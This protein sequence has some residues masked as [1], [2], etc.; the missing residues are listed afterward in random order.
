MFKILLCENKNTFHTKLIEDHRDLIPTIDEFL[1]TIPGANTTNTWPW[2]NRFLLLETETAEYML[3]PSNI[4]CNYR[5]LKAATL[6]PFVIY[7]LIKDEVEVKFGSI[8]KDDVAYILENFPEQFDDETIK[9][10]DQEMK[11][12]YYFQ[13]YRTMFSICSE[14]TIG[15]IRTIFMYSPDSV[16]CLLET[17]KNDEAYENMIKNDP[18]KEEFYKEFRDAIKYGRTGFKMEVNELC[19]LD[20]A[21]E[22][23]EHM[24]SL[25][26][27][28]NL[29]SINIFKSAVYK[30]ISD[31]VLPD[32]CM[33]H[34]LLGYTGCAH[35]RIDP[36]PNDPKVTCK[37]DKNLG[38]LIFFAGSRP[39]GCP[40]E[41]AL[42][43]LR[44]SLAIT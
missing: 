32:G 30:Q 7:K 23:E 24:E 6:K 41:E 36:N 31:K 4:P 22:D 8:E 35:A 33:G 14:E 37:F 29:E 38:N 15:L 16:K 43:E 1:N 21:L 5:N 27:S 42:K 9:K 20:K 3:V 19:D 10:R 44:K 26:R 2:M 12:G 34:L 13:G 40:L 18:S 39:K 28:L 11:Y 17:L 25:L